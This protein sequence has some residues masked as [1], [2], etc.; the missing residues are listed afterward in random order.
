MFMSASIYFR[1]PHFSQQNTVSEAT[2]DM[3]L[4]C[5]LDDDDDVWMSSRSKT[6]NK[7]QK[8]SEEYCIIYLFF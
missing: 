4:N 3:D 6:I 8:V 1:I 5:L 2:F 7:P